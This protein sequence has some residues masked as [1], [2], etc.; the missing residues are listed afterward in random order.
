MATEEDVKIQELLKYCKS[1][2]ISALRASAKTQISNNLDI[3]GYVIEE[4]SNDWYGLAE[5]IGYSGPEIRK[6]ERA[7]SPTTT[8]LDN[9]VTRE[10]FSPYVETLIKYLLEIQRLDVIIV[11]EKNI[12]K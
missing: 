4:Y 11:C 8:L 6:F 12:S 9:W 7:D 10:D 2:P 3:E 1:V 5:I